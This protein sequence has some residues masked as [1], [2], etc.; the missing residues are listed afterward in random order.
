[1]NFRID[2][3]RNCD[4]SW[5]RNSIWIKDNC[6]FSWILIIIFLINWNLELF[7]WGWE[8]RDEGCN[9]VVSRW[10]IFWNLLSQ[11]IAVSWSFCPL[12]NWILNISDSKIFSS[13]SEPWNLN[14]TPS[15]GTSNQ[16]ELK[17][18]RCSFSLGAD[19]IIK[20]WVGIVISNCCGCNCELKT[21]TRYREWDRSI[22]AILVAC[23]VW[24]NQ[25]VFSWL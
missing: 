17:E 10:Q 15:A 18:V 4:S 7:G 20:A 24:S 11:S 23:W 25:G 13:R 2:Y 8:A 9:F 1:M 14:W 19:L 5:L 6:Q 12:C 22:K 16:T 3:V 21:W